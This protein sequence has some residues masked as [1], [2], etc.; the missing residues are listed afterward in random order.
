MDVD[1]GLKCPECGTK[2]DLI[3]GRFKGLCPGCLAAGILNE[4]PISSHAPAT[5]DP[6]PVIPLPPEVAAAPASAR[7]GKF[8]LVT[9]LGTGGSGDVWKAWDTVLGRWVALK[10]FH[11]VDTGDLAR[12]QREAQTAARFSHS[13]IASIYEIGEH[14]G[15]HHIAMQFVDGVTL[16]KFPRRDR[17]L[18]VRIIRD[19]A[20]AVGEAH[21][22]GIVHR[23]L[24][25]A[26]IGVTRQTD[27]HHATILDF[28]LARPIEGGRKLT[29]SGLVVGTPAYMPPEQ[30]RGEVVDGRADVY[31]LGATLYH[32]LTGKL[33]FTGP[34][35]YEILRKV[36]EQDPLAP[37][38][39]DHLIPKDLETVILKSLEKDRTRRYASAQELADD[40]DRFL[41][42]EPILA[43]PA[44]ALYRLRLNLSKRKAVVAAAIL[45]VGLVA[46]AAL[47]I[48]KWRSEATARLKLE[49][50][51]TRFERARPHIESGTAVLQRMKLRMRKAYS[52]QDLKLLATEAGKHFDKALEFAPGHPEA[53]LG[54]AR[55][56][57]MIDDKKSALEVLDLAIA[58]DADFAPAYLE[59]VSLR[60]D[61]FIFAG[62]RHRRHGSST[63][64][65][66]PSR[67][68]RE[69]LEGDLRKT[70]QLS[71]DYAQQSYARALLCFADGD[72]KRAAA[73]L[74]EYLI[75]DP[76]D[77]RGHY[78]RGHALYHLDEHQAALDSFNHS[79]ECDTGYAA[80][81]LM[82]ALA[83]SALKFHD[84]AIDDCTRAIELGPRNATAFFNRGVIKSVKEDLEGAIADY[85]V[86]IQL[87]PQFASAYFNRAHSQS[88]KNLHD[89]AIADYD[90]VIILEPGNAGA[91]YNRAREKWLQGRY[92]EAVSDFDE[93]LKLDSTPANSNAYW[94]RARAKQALGQF[95][96]A[97]AD[98]SA[99]LER[100]PMIAS[101]FSSRAGARAAL[102]HHSEAILDYSRAI[103]IEPDSVEHHYSRGN[104][105]LAL[106]MYPE[107]IVDFTRSIELNANHS[108]ALTNRGLARERLGSTEEALA[109]YSAAIERDP[110]RAEAYLNRG[111]LRSQQGLH[112][113]AISDLERGLKL[114]PADRL[115]RVDFEKLL[116]LVRGRL[117]NREA[118][119]LYEES[120]RLW[121]ADRI[122]EVVEKLE[123][124]VQNW[125]ATR[126]GIDAAYNLACAHLRLKD[127][128]TALHWLEKAI[129]LGY[130]DVAHLE[131]DPDLELL[132]DEVRYKRLVE[133]LKQK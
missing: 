89:E 24:K 80:A 96:D 42:R 128:S 81:M 109:D 113:E 11:H 1:A 59:R 79:L 122:P 34:N 35:V 53:L 12:F 51:R 54:K 25:P 63:P 97:I 110:S 20:R 124:L 114:M 4:G 88:V 50:R 91:L 72:Y 2:T 17:N 44:G 31:A 95:T 92:R 6:A 132:R 115:E 102:G 15:R 126:W 120:Y 130:K 94:G 49:E 7:M 131:Q 52:P 66:P 117:K 48:P 13:G 116:G 46:T 3:R 108:Q 125:P 121:K 93:S 19:A 65:T 58:S 10:V 40:L 33:P 30:A 18:L 62:L 41:Q 76:D 77:A 45:A 118:A 47:L 70:E 16:E 112:H 29:V 38:A 100:N 8:T 73:G 129:E 56:C 103:D 106:R 64:I 85:G 123:K 23:D 5:L 61:E 22:M 14:E 98:Y 83:K 71:R 21:A 68:L 9:K 133:K 127:K 105:R 82:R 55:I 111:A 75:R 119:A 78:W 57:S 101:I 99:A 26:N 28:G 36:Q 104:A 67:T 39:I 84:D 86:A 43:R 32:V 69:Q 37:R 27:G 107:A 60:L 74:A 87:D 90:R